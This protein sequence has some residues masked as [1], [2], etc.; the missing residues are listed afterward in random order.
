MEEWQQTLDVVRQL[1][2]T[3]AT[4]RDEVTQHAG[5]IETMQAAIDNPK[6][7]R[8]GVDNSRR[9][10][11][12]DE[13]KKDKEE[14][15]KQVEGKEEQ[16]AGDESGE[17]KQLD[18]EEEEAD[19]ETSVVEEDESARSD[20]E[21]AREAERGHANRTAK[22][23]SWSQPPAKTATEHTKA[24]RLSARQRA[25][26]LSKSQPQP[27][28][29]SEK[30]LV[31]DDIADIMEE[32]GEQHSSS[33]PEERAAVEKVDQQKVRSEQSKRGRNS[34]LAGERKEEASG[35]LSRLAEGAR[36][37]A[38]RAAAEH[39]RK[40]Q[41]AENALR[42][43]Q[44][45]QRREK[46]RM[47]ER[48]QAAQQQT[49]QQTGKKEES[50]RR[51]LR[52]SLTQPS[53]SSLRSVTARLTPPVRAADDTHKRSSTRETRST[54]RRPAESTRLPLASQSG[55]AATGSQEQAASAAGEERLAA[56]LS[57][58]A[59][60][61]CAS[62]K[63]TAAM[64]RKAVSE[65]D[66]KAVAEHV[67]RV[68]SHKAE[69]I[70][71][72]ESETQLETVADHTQRR[73]VRIDA[74]PTASSPRQMQRGV[75]QLAG[76]AA[77]GKRS[78][79]QE[80]TTVSDDKM[81]NELVENL[82]LTIDKT[83]S[84]RPVAR[85]SLPAARRSEKRQRAQADSVEQRAASSGHTTEWSSVPPSYKRCK[86]ALTHQSPQRARSTAAAGAD[87]QRRKQQERED[88]AQWMAVTERTV[89]TE[90]TVNTRT[91]ERTHSPLT[92]FAAAEM[93]PPA[94]VTV[95]KSRTAAQRRLQASEE[96]KKGAKVK[97]PAN[98]V[99]QQPTTRP[100]KWSGSASLSALQPLGR[101]LLQSPAP[102]NVFSITEVMAFCNRPVAR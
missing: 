67:K 50:A 64:K 81:S 68:K 17:D 40:K 57:A 20:D 6:A 79:N 29:E 41:D 33:E 47:A 69:V 13:Q 71:K 11:P 89:T 65:Q 18:T 86:V 84:A 60:L 37:T 24:V 2:T 73:D 66:G 42:T 78:T 49:A 36:A 77:D 85:V 100:L 14:E 45:R 51:P 27:V 83:L 82:I 4:L 63:V 55:A 72:P 46:Q 98:V 52:S 92:R 70:G 96:A 12:V 32:E 53:P 43:V 76:R 101:V 99:Q 21:V 62:R 93:R 1:R 23:V 10:K 28:K 48:E 58:S 87:G 39:Q 61:D 94:A 38:E 7:K 97:Q 34:Q 54:T 102:N 88:I 59:A 5:K 26:A 80:A 56:P 22:R 30:L 95:P 90:T 9:S 74:A 44:E 3:R 91:V 25:A 31:Y 19:E 35:E 8:L 15:D 16:V 75:S